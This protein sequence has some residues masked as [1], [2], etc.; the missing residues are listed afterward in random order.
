MKKFSNIDEKSKVLQEQKPKFNK[1]VDI[2]IRENLQVSYD[3]DCDDILT[4]KLTIDGSN[5]LVEKLNIIIEKY[6]SQTTDILTETI[7]YQYGN[8][9]D[10]KSINKEIEILENYLYLDI[11]PSP[12]DIFSLE[13]MTNEMISED[14]LVLK[15]LNNIP[16]D[17][18]DYI[19][20]QESKKFF[21]N[22]NTIRLR[23]IGPVQGWELYF[24]CNFKNYGTTIDSKEDKYKKFL[25]ENKE[26]I[27]DF[28]NAT[29]SLVGASFLS[30]NKSFTLI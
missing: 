18:M 17:Y 12:Y 21:E 1:L 26:F 2:L 11:I 5:N 7:Q 22:E 24:E 30:L 28:L 25:T 8:Q 23:Y 10:Q 29:T 27:G 20:L 4:R 13:D 3:G 14:T 19:N 9:I 6:K 16:T 15:S